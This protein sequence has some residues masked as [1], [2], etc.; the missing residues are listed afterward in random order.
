MNNFKQF[1]YEGE[2]TEIGERK[3][4]FLNALPKGSFQHSLIDHKFDKINSMEE[5]FKYFYE[6][7]LDESKTVKNNSYITLKHVATGKYL[8]S[9]DVY[10]DGYL[11]S[12]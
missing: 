11:V 7:F 1:C 5:L 10:H 9:C 2:I 4:L 12:T 3:R 8:S 6:S